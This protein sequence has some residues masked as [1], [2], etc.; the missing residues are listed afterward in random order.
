M[1]A[2]GNWAG[3]VPWRRA[4]SAHW[5]ERARLLWP[6][7]FTAGINIFLLPVILNQAHWLLSPETTHWWIDGIAA[8]IGVLLASY[9][10]DREIFPQLNFSKWWRQA[11]TAWGYQVGTWAPL[12]AA[13]LLMPEKPGTRMLLV[14]GGYL[15][16]HVSIQRGLL[17]R[18]LRW[19]NYMTPAGP[20]VQGIVDTTAAR[21]GVTVRA[22]SQLGGQW[23]NAFAFP[24]TREL[25]F[26]NRLLEICSNE[27]VAAICSH[28]LAHLTESKAA[29]AGRMLMSLRFFPFIFALPATSSFGAVGFA[30]PFLAM[31]LIDFFGRRFSQRM[32]ER[33]DTLAAAEQ[34]NEGVYARA[35]ETIYRANHIPAVN[36]HNAHTHPHLYD[37]MLAAGITP[38]YPRPMKPRR[39]TLAGWLY[40]VTFG[41][42]TV[43][44]VA[45]F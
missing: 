26:S 10:F 42:L 35:L 2:L 14:V 6:A 43:L 22:T 11:I 24:F 8:L 36:P 41:V 13:G 7:R 39:L 5:A 20:R 1:Y 28:E 19:V 21:L 45:R 9:Y 40:V 16:L 44:A 33:A 12:I 29:L 23:A 37:R 4:A 32:E 25:A 30:L 34:T 15:A 38:D 3:L 17:L 27:E 18:F 31:V